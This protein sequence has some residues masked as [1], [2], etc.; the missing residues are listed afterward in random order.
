MN[1]IASVVVNNLL[2]TETLLETLYYHDYHWKCYDHNIKV[3]GL[4]L[5][6]LI[7]ASVK[8]VTDTV[9]IWL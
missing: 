1:V 4:N 7:E 9:F 5:L 8:A 3:K 2:R 6:K